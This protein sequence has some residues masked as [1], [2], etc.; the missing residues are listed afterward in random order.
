MLDGDRRP[1]TRP[2]TPGLG[3]RI[4]LIISYV[5]YIL[6][7]RDILTIYRLSILYSQISLI[8]PLYNF[9][10]PRNNQDKFMELT[11][12][13]GTMMTFTLNRVL[14]KL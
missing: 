9:L 5:P 4:Y 8:L 14:L 1:Y 7:Q 3:S 10:I 12:S 6:D 11:P 13:T 2:R